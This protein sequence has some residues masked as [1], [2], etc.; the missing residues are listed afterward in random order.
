MRAW[1]DTA[2]MS[3]LTKEIYICISGLNTGLF[4]PGPNPFIFWQPWLKGYDAK[5][6]P[7]STVE[8]YAAG[9]NRSGLIRLSN[10]RDDRAKIAIDTMEKARS[11]ACLDVPG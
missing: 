11:K 7:L 2:E 6:V 9:S 3:R 5:H 1:T 10:S 8:A 4:F